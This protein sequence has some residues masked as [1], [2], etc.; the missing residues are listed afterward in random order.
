MHNLLSPPIATAP[1][2]ALPAPAKISTHRLSSETQVQG[3]SSST[4]PTVSV[5]AGGATATPV[6][7]PVIPA[8]SSMESMRQYIFQ[9]QHV[10]ARHL[11]QLQQTLPLPPGTTA[12]QTQASPQLLRLLTPSSGST[13]VTTTT[14]VSSS[15]PQQ[16][17][18]ILPSSAPYAAPSLPPSLVETKKIDAGN[19]GLPPDLNVTL[20]KPPNSNEAGTPAGALPISA[21]V[22]NT[23][24]SKLSWVVTFS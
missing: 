15:Q 19:V 4:N 20:I 6:H 17:G 9:H 12:Q 1:A 7:A 24:S 10:M 11:Q 2:L 22:P 14:V 3:P 21:V 16:I 23:A 13:P 5:L 8:F 18:G